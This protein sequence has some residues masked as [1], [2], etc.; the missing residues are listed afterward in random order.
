AVG[1][2][3]SLVIP[4][5][6]I[7]EEDQIIASL[8]TG[9]RIEHFETV[10]M[11]N[12]GQRITVSLTV[13]PIKDD[14]GRVI[15]ASKI[16]RDI[17]DQKRAES[18]RQR[19]VAVIENSTDFIGMCDLQ[20]VPFF[21]NRAGLAMLGVENIE[22]GRHTAVADFFFPQDQ[23]VMMNEFFPSVLENGHGEIE[24]RFRH[25]KTGE[26]HW[27]AYKVLTLTDAANQPVG[28]ATV[29]QDV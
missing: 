9:E 3:I 15:G 11:R 27:M 28:F 25:F 14:S 5:E 20:G 8:R 23:P 1:R 22:E 2:H 18:D 24:I 4:P 21:I 16:V 29:S 13:S 26:A 12:D 10:R 6:R 19:F 17:S 7:A